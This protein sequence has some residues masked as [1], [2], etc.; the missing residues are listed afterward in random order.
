VIV[1]RSDVQYVSKRRDIRHFR[2]SF[3]KPREVVNSDAL[4]TFCVCKKTGGWTHKTG[5]RL[6][7]GRQSIRQLSS[8]SPDDNPKCRKFSLRDCAVSFIFVVL[9]R[10]FEFYISLI[11]IRIQFR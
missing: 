9:E 4:T 10:Y 5:K 2:E 6:A 11:F 7:I 1:L 3:E 8:R